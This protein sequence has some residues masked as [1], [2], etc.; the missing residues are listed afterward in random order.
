ML[1]CKVWIAQ[2]ILDQRCGMGTVHLTPCT[3]ALPSVPWDRPALCHGLRYY[4]RWYD[5]GP[6]GRRHI[7]EDQLN[8]YCVQ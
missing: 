2:S 1:V 4:L 3:E 7:A 5:S 6:E 8:E